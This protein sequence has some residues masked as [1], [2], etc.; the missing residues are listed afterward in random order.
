MDVRMPEMSGPDATRAIRSTNNDCRNIPIIALTADA[1]EV[2][3]RT[4]F[5][6]GM[7]ACVGHVQRKRLRMQRV[8]IRVGEARRSRFDRHDVRGRA[9]QELDRAGAY[10]RADVQCDSAGG[11]CVRRDRLPD[12]DQPAA[13]SPA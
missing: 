2:H 8:G 12:S 1:M 11:A 6:A 7:D 10:V 3:I 5:E 9:Q 4:Y 13:V